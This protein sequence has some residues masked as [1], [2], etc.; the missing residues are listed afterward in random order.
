SH[1]A[2]E[3]TYYH[4][5]KLLANYSNAFYLRA[6]RNSCQGCGTTLFYIKRSSE[7]LI[8]VV[9][10]VLCTGHRNSLLVQATVCLLPN[11]KIRVAMMCV[12][13]EKAFN[14]IC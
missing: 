6:F 4:G 11:D 1:L 7:P 3:V 14:V 8:N 10:H 13:C 12:R 5:R 9:F 2:E